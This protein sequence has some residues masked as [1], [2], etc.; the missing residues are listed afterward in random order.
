MSNGVAREHIQTKNPKE[1]D[2][3]EKRGKKQLLSDCNSKVRLYI[4]L[5][6]VAIWATTQNNAMLEQK[7]SVE[8]M[9]KNVLLQTVTKQLQ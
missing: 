5:S 3:R 2:G 9:Y 4:V 7:K 8:P 6:N 1:L